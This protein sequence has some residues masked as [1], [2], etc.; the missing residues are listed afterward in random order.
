MKKLKG[1]TL[2]EL[3]IVI[4]VIAV[5]AA[6]LVPSMIGY[7]VRSKLSTANANAK[8]VYNA[9]DHYCVEC[10][11]KGYTVDNGVIAFSMKW[12]N[13]TPDTVAF[14]GVHIGEA[15]RSTVG[16]SGQNAGLFS[17]R[18]DDNLPSRSAWARNVND[19]FIGTF[20]ILTTEPS[21]NVMSDLQL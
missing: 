6:M 13:N 15:V 21:D 3:I 20:P 8:L 10:M 2:I 4:A 11:S 9:S 16:S 5:I 12:I 19:H 1:F 18:I 17:V 7:V 14:D